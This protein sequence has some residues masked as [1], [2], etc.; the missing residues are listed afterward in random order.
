MMEASKESHKGRDPYLPILHTDIS[1]WTAPA[2]VTM[3]TKTLRVG[4]GSHTRF[5]QKN[6][7]IDPD[8]IFCHRDILKNGTPPPSVLARYGAI[9]EIL[10]FYKVVFEYICCKMSR[11]KSVTSGHTNLCHSIAKNIQ[12]N[13]VSKK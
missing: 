2:F 8:R 3:A 11:G 6:H 5:K 12:Q 4:Y 13:S 7:T 10:R 1:C 9:R